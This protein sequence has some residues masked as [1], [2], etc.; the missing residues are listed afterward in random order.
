[1]TWTTETPKQPG[2][3]WHRHPGTG[4]GPRL[5]LLI[6]LRENGRLSESYTGIFAKEWRGEWWSERIKPPSLEDSANGR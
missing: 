2:Y 4:D 6:D 5:I 3:Y 1:M